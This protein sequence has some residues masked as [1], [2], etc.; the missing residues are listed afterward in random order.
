MYLKR[1]LTNTDC[2]P[3]DWQSV[4]ASYCWFVLFLSVS[5]LYRMSSGAGKDSPG[6]LRKQLRKT[7]VAIP[8]HTHMMIR[9]DT[10]RS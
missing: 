6:Q 3:V 2:F 5:Y 10:P 8:D 7:K 4:A 1:D 9:K